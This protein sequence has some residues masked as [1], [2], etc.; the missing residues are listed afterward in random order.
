MSATPWCGPLGGVPTGRHPGAV[1]SNPDPIAP[2]TGM[3]CFAIHPRQRWPKEV[4]DFTPWLAAHIDLLAT[5]LGE[6]LTLV[7]REMLLGGEGMRADL[8]AR[9]AAGGLAVIE[10]QMGRTD[11]RHLGQLVAYAAVDEVCLLVWVI[12]DLSEE[13]CVR[14]AHARALARLNAA[15][16]AMGVR[17]VAVEACVE[18]D[19]H[20]AGTGFDTVELRPRLRLVD[21]QRPW[22]CPTHR[23]AHPPLVV[24]RANAH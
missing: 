2:P 21:L 10:A 9:T 12:A 5:C 17:F 22:I 6:P 18:S 1:T 4:R 7:G 16:T 23:A 3:S 15:F 8:V 19:W 20:P 14:P 11:A 13:D 24:R